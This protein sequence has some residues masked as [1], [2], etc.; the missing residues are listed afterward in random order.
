MYLNL[1]KE[2]VRKDMKSAHSPL[3]LWD[4]Y[5]EHCAAILSLPVRNLFQ[6]QGSNPYTATFGEEGTSQTCADSH[7]RNG[8]ISMM[9]L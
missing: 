9:T 4:Y 1:L 5:A 8:Y 7:G 3:V 2:S 6:L